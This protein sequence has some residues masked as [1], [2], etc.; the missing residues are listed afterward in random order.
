MTK[1]PWAA[2][3]DLGGTKIQILQINSN[4]T[5]GEQLRCPTDISGGAEAVQNEIINSIK[6]LEQKIGS[7]PAAIGIGIAGQVDG[8]TGVVT[9]APNL[10]WKNVPIKSNLH[11]A[12]GI[13]IAITNDVRAATWGE[14]LHGAGRGCNNL[15]CIFVGTGI[16]GGIVVNGEML[17]GASNTAGEI[18][19]MIVALD[20]PQCTCGSYGCMEAFAGGWAMTKRAKEQMVRD[21]ESGITL[22]TMAQGD[23][24]AINGRLVTEAARLEDPLSCHIIEE[25]VAALA[26]GTTSLVNILNPERIVFGGGVIEGMPELIP[27]IEERVRASALKAATKS[28]TIARA[29]LKN[30]A[31]AIGAGA[32]ALR[33]IR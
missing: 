23:I 25:A 10:K 19:H 28:L 29:E 13:P 11:K 5:V 26:A 2:G 24:D 3:V 33:E 9:F 14:W 7:P 31:G 12:L 15:L 17:S 1:Q 6:I 22:L 30:N 20:G 8:D 27:L 32:L 21:P 18:G 16:G 4:G